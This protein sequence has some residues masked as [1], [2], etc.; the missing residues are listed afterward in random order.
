VLR[1]PE[2][3]IVLQAQEFCCAGDLVGEYDNLRICFNYPTRLHA[4]GCVCLLPYHLCFSLCATPQH[5][6]SPGP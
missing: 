5:S 1:P 6:I 3:T 4:S 2:L